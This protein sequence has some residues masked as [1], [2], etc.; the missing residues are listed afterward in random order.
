MEV[1]GNFH[2]PSL[3]KWMTEEYYLHGLEYF[4]DP[5]GVNKW[6]FSQGAK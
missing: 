3:Q 6:V 2:P 1:H 5:H 4:L